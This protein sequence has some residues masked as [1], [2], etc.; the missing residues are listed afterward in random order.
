MYTFGTRQHA[1]NSVMNM[2]TDGTYMK[3]CGSIPAILLESI[4]GFDSHTPHHPM[5]SRLVLECKEKWV[6]LISATKLKWCEQIDYNFL[7][8]RKEMKLI[9]M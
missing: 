6:S 5:W 7:M 3:V 9:F 1:L 4:V 2:H 8:I